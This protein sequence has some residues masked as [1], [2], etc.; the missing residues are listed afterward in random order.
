MNITDTLKKY[1]DLF[2]N[3]NFEYAICGGIAANI[4]RKEIRGTQD[5][6]ISILGDNEESS[7]R[8]ILEALNFTIGLASKADLEGGP[9]F[10]RKKNKDPLIIVGRPKDKPS[11]F[12]LDFILSSMPWVSSA[13][14]RAQSNKLDLLFGVHPVITKED[15]LISKLFALRDKATRY[16]DLDDIQN[17]LL[18]KL[19]LDEEYLIQK[20]TEYSLFFK[21]D[22]HDLL[23]VSISRK[24]RK[25]ERGL[26]K[27]RTS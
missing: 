2:K 7:V 26:R 21:K 12:G 25:I 3:Y 11:L 27:T 6:D 5:L 1:T 20:L 14:R 18:N 8:N 23:P 10:A 13:V 9:L 17:I 24:S 4:Y 15:L 19:E 22:F 16:K